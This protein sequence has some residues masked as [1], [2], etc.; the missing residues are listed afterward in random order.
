[1]PQLFIGREHFIRPDG[2]EGPL[3][4][5]HISPYKHLRGSNWPL[6]SIHFSLSGCLKIR[7]HKSVFHHQPKE[8][9]FFVQSSLI[10]N[11]QIVGSYWFQGH[12][13]DLSSPRRPTALFYLPH[14]GRHQKQ[15]Q[16]TAAHSAGSEKE[17]NDQLVFVPISDA[18]VISPGHK[19][20][21][22]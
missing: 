11:F 8:N 21:Y 9:V 14:D 2:E 19:A 4:N 12:I 13:T 3:K 17:E 20:A 16:E 10:A 6:K 7:P 22:V 1:M 18:R 5:S 15:G